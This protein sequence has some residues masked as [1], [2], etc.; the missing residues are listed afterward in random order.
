LIFQK[1]G[2]WPVFSYFVVPDMVVSVQTAECRLYHQVMLAL[3]TQ[4]EEHVSGRHNPM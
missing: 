4:Q 1:T 3:G 2:R